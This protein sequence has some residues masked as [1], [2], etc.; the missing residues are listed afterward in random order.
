MYFALQQL[1]LITKYINNANIKSIST[2]YT[3]VRGAVLFDDS[4]SDEATKARKELHT[5]YEERR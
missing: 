4:P 5:K 3:D 2:L 1:N